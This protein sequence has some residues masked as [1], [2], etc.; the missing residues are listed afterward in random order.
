L[1]GITVYKVKVLKLINDMCE[2]SKYK[3]APIMDIIKELNRRRG[4][5][6]KVLTELK[7]E[8]YITN[9]IRGGWMLTDYGKKIIS[10]YVRD[11]EDTKK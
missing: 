2:T 9:P 11:E 8:G 7:H 10:A 6:A 3:I 1:S 5:V 4:A